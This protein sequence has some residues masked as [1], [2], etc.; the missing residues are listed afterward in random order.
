MRTLVLRV[1]PLV[2]LS[3]GLFSLLGSFW[4][5][6][7]PVALVALAAYVLAAAILLPGWR[8]PLACLGFTAIAAVTIVYSTWR[9]GG[10]DVEEALT[11]GLRIVVLA[12]PGSVMAG[13][14]DPSRFAD[15]AAQRLHV[16]PR[17][18]AAFAAALQKFTTFGLAWQQLERVRRVRGFGPSRNPVATGAYAA[19]MS[20]A[21]LVQAMRGATATSI[22][23]DARGFATAQRRTWAEPA[24]WTRLDTGGIVVAALLGAVPVVA[25]LL[26]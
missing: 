8:Y 4:I 15:Y 18:V 9:L 3:V 13:Y 12:W 16:P 19:N 14:L 10:R 26:L 11:A 5:R 22:A 2:Q 6:S 25:R 23:M 21:L 1:N 17:L 7:L 20:F 24:P